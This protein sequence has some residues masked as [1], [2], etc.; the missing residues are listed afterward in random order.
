MSDVCFKLNPLTRQLGNVLTMKDTATIELFT[1][2][3]KESNVDLVINKI[4]YLLLAKK[5][6]PGMRL[7]SEKELAESLSVGR[8]SIREAMKILSAFGIVEIRRGDGMYITKSTGKSLFDPLLFDLILSQ[9]DKKNL[10]E[11]REAIELGLIR[12][13]LK[14]ANEDDLKRI[15]DEFQD[16]EHKILNGNRDPQVLTQCDL[17]FHMALGRAT[18]NKLLE[19]I[20]NFVLEYFAPSIEKTHFKEQSGLNALRLHKNILDALITRDFDKAI[21]AINESLQD[22]VDLSMEDY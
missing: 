11:L 5:L 17:N 16:M 7:P 10:L 1:S 9:P 8:S 2:P 19:K 13:I 3:R 6:T 21:A 4:K 12:P 20:Y 15:E 22:W 14:N 18:K